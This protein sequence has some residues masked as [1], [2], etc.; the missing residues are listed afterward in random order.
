VFNDDIFKFI[1][2]E[3]GEFVYLFGVNKP[4]G[5]KIQKLYACTLMKFS[6]A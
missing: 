4:E 5:K 2:E 6:I 3:E 1:R